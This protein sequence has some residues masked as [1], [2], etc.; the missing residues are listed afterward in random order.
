MSLPASFRFE[1]DGVQFAIN[2]GV[3]VRIEPFD[4]EP[5][6]LTNP[7]TINNGAS[8]AL[9]TPSLTADYYVLW[10]NESTGGQQIGIGHNSGVTISNCDVLLQPGDSWEMY[11]AQLSFFAIASLAGGLL[12]G[13]IKGT[14]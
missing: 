7:I 5:V 8:T 4:T 13:S 6:L 12:R 14:S 2:A 9:F 1:L 10:V 3:L 11:F